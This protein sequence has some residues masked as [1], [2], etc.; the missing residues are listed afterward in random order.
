MPF[1]HAVIAKKEEKPHHLIT[2]AGRYIYRDERDKTKYNKIC[3]DHMDITARNFVLKVILMSVGG[4]SAVSGPI[5]AYFTDGIK[6]STT[7]LLFPFIE[8]ESDAHFITNLIFQFS[9]YFHAFF[10]YLV[11]EI[12][13]VLIEN[14]A[15]LVPKL[16]KH[17]SGKLIEESEQQELSELQLILTVK[18]IVKMAVD[19]DK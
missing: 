18:N 19:H 15:S 2:F 12:A 10:L 14:V 5:I 17:E 13:M 16:V 4:V 9:I 8:E 1:I 6:T 3:S 11:M 7:D